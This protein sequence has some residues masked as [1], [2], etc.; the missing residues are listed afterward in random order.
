MTC[1]PGSWTGAGSLKDRRAAGIFANF[2]RDKIRKLSDAAKD[3][4]NE[5]CQ[6]VDSGKE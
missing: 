1:Q 6:A 2:V 3:L 5:Y 4:D